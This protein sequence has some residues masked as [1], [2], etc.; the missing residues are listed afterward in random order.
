MEQYNIKNVQDYEMEIDIKEVFFALLQKWYLI[1]LAGILM[2]SLFLG[3]SKF[4]LTEKFES[5]TS[6]YIL[7]QK[8]EDLTYSDLQLGTILTKDYE[9]LIKSRTVLEEVTK[10]LKLDIPYEVLSGMVKVTVPESTRIVQISVRTTSPEL[11]Q[12]IADEVREVA[13]E[14]ISD[15]MNVDA[16][17]VVD[18]A[19]L[20]TGKCSP[21]VTRNTVMGGFFGVLIASAI[22]LLITMLNDTI[23]TQDDVKKYLGLNTMGVIPLAAEGKSKKHK[24]ASKKSRE[25]MK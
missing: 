21:N 7:N 6:I 11:S 4:V 16:V 9:V 18:K 2:A 19:N 15:V 8:S 17:K 3:V 1:A 10:N 23:R 12:K 20:P 14:N 25:M 22:I 24:K 5:K 13:S